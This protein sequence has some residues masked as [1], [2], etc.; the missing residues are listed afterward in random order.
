MANYKISTRQ[1]KDFLFVEKHEPMGSALFE[2]VNDLYTSY[3]KNPNGVECGLNKLRRFLERNHSQSSARKILP[4]YIMQSLKNKFPKLAKNKKDLEL[5]EANFLKI[6]NG[7]L[8]KTDP[9][10][11]IKKRKSVLEKRAA[12][13]NGFKLFGEDWQVTYPPKDSRRE[14]IAESEDLAGLLKY[15]LLNANMIF[16]A[17]NTNLILSTENFYR[18]LRERVR[19]SM[20]SF[21][22]LRTRILAPSVHSANQFCEFSEKFEVR[23]ITQSTEYLYIISTP[24]AFRFFNKQIYKIT[25]RGSIHHAIRE[26][27]DPSIPYLELEFQKAR[28]LAN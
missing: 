23:L 10:L 2:D 4:P 15:D 1:F 25:S 21:Q 9:L 13:P 7:W 16:L 14:Y 8:E 18:D 24:D 17:G 26:D 20:L 19:L 11:Q 6:F 28:I 5:V 22:T 12:E 27:G 3:M